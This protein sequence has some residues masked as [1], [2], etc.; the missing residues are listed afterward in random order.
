MFATDYYNPFNKIKSTSNN[1][2][3]SPN[4]PIL[5]KTITDYFT[6]KKNLPIDVSL[7]ENIENGSDFESGDDTNIDPFDKEYCPYTP[8][9]SYLPLTNY[10]AF[11]SP[12]VD[13]YFPT[14]VVVP[15][16]TPYKFLVVDDN[17]I[18]LKILCRQLLKIF[19]Y[20]EVTKLQDS[21]KVKPILDTKSFD[22]V[23]L[24]I[25][26]PEVN[27]IELAQH[28]RCSERF[29]QWGVI[30]VTTLTSVRDLNTYKN[31]GIDFTFEKP[32]KA[33]LSEIARIIDEI[34]RQRKFGLFS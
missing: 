20:A 12:I 32:M 23:F 29:D 31:C 10:D 28:M 9:T 30:A 21:T 3:L 8:R 24:D 2:Q 6:I 25:E 5:S 14:D 16:F 11:S 34:I 17:I 27:G 13:P 15:Q 1:G 19:P 7:P 26:M 4:P 22:L 33:D 18:N